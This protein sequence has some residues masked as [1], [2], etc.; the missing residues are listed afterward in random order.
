ML[1]TRLSHTNVLLT[2]HGFQ[3]TAMI[4]FLPPDSSIIEI[5]PYKYFKPSYFTLSAQFGLFHYWFQVQPTTAKDKGILQYV[6]LSTCMQD[7]RCRS[8]A[9]NQNI[10]LEEEDRQQI[11]H[12]LLRIQYGLV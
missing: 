4:L 6:R 8:Y 5:F 3:L 9:R 7:Q 10:Y 2:S 11:I 12:L 1:Y